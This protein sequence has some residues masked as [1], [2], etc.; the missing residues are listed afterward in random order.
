M[1]LR[2]ISFVFAFLLLLLPFFDVFPQ[3]YYYHN[4][5]IALQERFDG[6]VVVSKSARFDN[7]IFKK[8]IEQL[9]TEDYTLNGIFEN[10]AYIKSKHNTSQ[11]E[12]QNIKSIFTSGLR[13]IKFIAPVYY[14]ESKSVTQISTDE[15]IV[16]LNN[17]VNT[18]KLEILNFQNNV[19][20]KGFADDGK[21]YILKTTDLSSK[22][23]LELTAIYYQT[24][25]FEY[26]EPNFVYP[27]EGFFNW[28]PNDSYYPIQWPLNN[29]GQISYTGGYT[30]YGDASTSG[31]FPGA[32]MRVS[33]AW[34]YVKGNQNVIVAVFDTGV[35]S[36]HPDL[37]DNLITGYNAYA[38]TNT[39]T[40]DPGSHGTCT[41]GIIG[42]RS[43]N[44]TGVAGIVGGDNGSNHCKVCSYRLVDNTGTF[45]SNANIARAFDTAR[46]RGV[47]V[48]SNSWGGGSPAT[49]LSTAINNLANN[50]RSGLGC[51][52]LFSSGNDGK[53]PPNYPSYLPTVVCVGASTNIDT[54]KSP[55][56]GDQFWWGGCYGEDANG[57]LDLVAPTI[58][59]TTD[60]RGSGGYST[61]DYDSTFNGTSCSCPN[62]AGVAALIFSINSNFTRSQVLDYLF[63]GCEKIDNLPYSTNKT[64]GKWNPYTGYGRVNAYNS[65]R[66]AA[67]IDVTP[68]TINHTN[69][70]SVSS[71]TYPLTVSAE[72]LD[73]DGT[74]V[75]TSGNNAPIL[76]YRKNKNNTGWS[77]FASVN[78]SSN[79]GNTFYFKI[80]SSGLQTEIE[81]YF[82]A[83]DNTGNITTFPKNA[84]SYPCYTSI[85]TTTTESGT[86]AAFTLPTS[87][88]AISSNLNMSNYKILN[89]DIKLNLTHSYVSDFNLTL[90]SPSADTKRNRVCLFS[91]NGGAGANITNATVS[92]AGTYF[93]RESSAPYT[94]LSVKPEHNF[95]EL[96]GTNSGGNWRLLY[97]DGLA[98]DGGTLNSAILNIKRL[99]GTTSSCIRLD[100]DSD[101]LAILSAMSGGKDTIDFYVRNVGTANLIIS[102]HNFSGIS[103]AQYSVLNNP[104]LN[105]IPGD[106]T[107]FRILLN[108]TALQKPNSGNNSPLNN[109][110]VL[111]INN[112]DPSKSSFKVTL[113]NDAP[114]PV[115]LSSF[116]Y[117][118]T[119]RDVKL[120]W[121]TELE[122]NNAGFEVERAEDRS[123]KLEFSKIGYTKGQGTVNTVTNYIFE[124]KKLNSGKYKYRLKQIDVNGNF[125]YFALNSE[126]EIGVPSKFNLSQNYPNPFNPTTKIDFDLPFD[127]KI[128][129]VVYDITGRELKSIVN[130][131]LTA[132]YYTVSI[133]GSNLTSGIYLYRIIAKSADKDF[134]ATKKMMLIK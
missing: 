67:G 99:S 91:E 44:G 128:K 125:E 33:Q 32:D 83:K 10:F 106:S 73:Q 52:V 12:L 8:D 55:G 78:A 31:G 95:S 25:L 134:V 119:S 51:V 57:D 38:N 133:N 75:P 118:V 66:L 63:R 100:Y 48:S 71:S 16:K 102:S 40:T 41:I 105:V 21:A 47:H 126:V 42:A 20:I 111:N 60:I 122:V 93:W 62:A 131:A 124:D 97:Y 109:D 68:P 112:N 30:S 65:V 127:S 34:D 114:L 132:G 18:N 17:P 46:V 59:I 56:T 101:S 117:S 22:S 90:W 54:K 3:G 120:A 35:D 72:I 92:D 98:G 89:A 28:T 77:T 86:F 123:K 2:K 14:G 13:D 94:N 15:F 1:G 24:G 45:T 84:P 74:A 49:V 85:G 108:T 9:I 4:R 81:Y 11:S 43:N 129:I 29:T 96:L 27:A 19:I 130:E 7:Q 39:N 103:A 76:Y 121:K 58:T 116:S 36:L 79:S 50:G 23:A 110:A 70:T 37:K 115:S 107:L 5:Y 64:Y 26:A 113:T 88:V 87:G 69:L 6:L 80:P 61:T 53:N 82:S 104:S